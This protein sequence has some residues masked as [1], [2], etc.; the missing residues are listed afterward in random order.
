M[1]SPPHQHHFEDSQV[2]MQRRTIMNEL[3]RR[4]STV[5]VSVWT[6]SLSPEARR[7]LYYND[8]YK[9]LCDVVSFGEGRLEDCQ[10]SAVFF[11]YSSL[12]E[13][14]HDAMQASMEKFNLV[15]SGKTYFATLKEGY[16][17][18]K[19]GR[20]QPLTIEWYLL[21]LAPNVPCQVLVAEFIN[22]KH[23]N[24]QR[25]VRPKETR[26]STVKLERWRWTNWGIENGNTMLER[27]ATSNWKCPVCD[28]WNR[29]YF[30]ILAS[31][32]IFFSLTFQMPQR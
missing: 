24:P 30:V 21:T 8:S 10:P 14:F 27:R 17:L 9:S 19:L 22:T 11:T 29:R 2:L 16:H 15:L 7:L 28:S 26:R 20:L 32:A 31:N 5:A 13:R 4:S 23:T 25:L 3:Q 1:Q 18:S 6:A 12:Q